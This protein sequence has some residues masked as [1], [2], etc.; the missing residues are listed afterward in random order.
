MCYICFVKCI[1]NKFKN[2]NHE[3]A[4]ESGITNQNV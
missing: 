1:V 2:R 3:Q 4:R